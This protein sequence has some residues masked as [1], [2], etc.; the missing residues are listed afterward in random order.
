MKRLL[1]GKLMEAGTSLA[2]FARCCK[3][4]AAVEF[5]MIVPIMFLLFVGSIEFSQ[6][7][8][9]DRRVTQVASSTA[10]LVARERSIATSDVDGIM[11]II[12]HLMSPYDP[13]KLKLTLL[14]VYSSMTNAA[15]TKVCWSYNHNGG[16][17]NYSQDQTYTLPTGIVEAGSSVIVTEVRYNYDPLIFRYFITSTLPLEEKFFLKPRLSKSVQLDSRKCL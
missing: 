12:D 3:G 7:I 9:V 16:V 11:Q 14:N 10:D 4:V 6:A 2:S 17:N 8:T 13:S 5:A 1:R 15:D